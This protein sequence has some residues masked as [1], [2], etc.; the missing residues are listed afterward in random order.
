MSGALWG[1][2]KD[3]DGKPI[4]KNFFKKIDDIAHEIGEKLRKRGIEVSDTKEKFGTVRVY[5]GL[6]DDQVK[7]Y[8]AVYKAACKKYPRYK[9]YII[10]GADWIEYLETKR[11][12]K[13]AK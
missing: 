6:R 11:Q 8:Q 13:E 4:G 10:D 1:E 5:C 3:F 12:V 7:A 9:K 2:K